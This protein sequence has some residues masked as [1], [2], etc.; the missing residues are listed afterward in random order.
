[1][2]L[3]FQFSGGDS[4]RWRTW[5][6]EPSLFFFNNGRMCHGVYLTKSVQADM[7]SGRAAEIENCNFISCRLCN[8]LKFLAIT[9]FDNVL[10]TP[11]TR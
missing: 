10:S 1:M 3:I 9:V 8:G 4:P 5:G 11:L 2:M 6:V 7:N